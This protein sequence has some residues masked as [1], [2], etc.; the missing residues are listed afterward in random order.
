MN[1]NKISPFRAFTSVFELMLKR[2]LGLSLV[3]SLVFALSAFIAGVIALNSG[4]QPA[5]EELFSK[6]HAAFIAFLGLILLSVALGLASAGKTREEYTLSRLSLGDG[7]MLAARALAS[8]VELFFYWALLAASAFA[9]CAY[10]RAVRPDSFTTQTVFLGFY[11]STYLHNLVP[12]AETLVLIRNA[13]MLLAI[14]AC[15]AAS[16]LRF[17]KKGFSGTIVAMLIVV[18]FAFG[19]DVGTTGNSIFSIIVSVIAAAFSVYW[20]LA[21][22]REA[23]DGGDDDEKAPA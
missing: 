17:G 14:A 15:C 6:S 20:R 11:R 4:S 2:T 22:A 16:S 12:L 18:R 5:P 23:E 8:A 3:I 10:V 9:L 7:G 19:C 1:R 21:A 13:A